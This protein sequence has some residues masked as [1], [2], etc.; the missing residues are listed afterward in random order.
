MDVNSLVEMANQIGEFFDSMPDRE[1][2]VDGVA[3]HIHRFWA[4]RMRIALLNGLDDPEV[5]SELKP[6]VL[7]ALTKHRVALTPAGAVVT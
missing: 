5:A 4:P 6:I 2:A 1:E 7:E 3:D